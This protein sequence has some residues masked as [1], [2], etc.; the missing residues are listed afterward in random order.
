MGTKPLPEPMTY[1]HFDPFE[2]SSVKFITIF[3]QKYASENVV[4]NMAPI[5]SGLIVFK[6]NPIVIIC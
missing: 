6:E 1:C 5:Y 2:Q 3:F 4:C